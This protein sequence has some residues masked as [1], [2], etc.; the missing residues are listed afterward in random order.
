MIYL[1][2]DLFNQTYLEAYR[3]YTISWMDMLDCRNENEVYSVNWLY[4]DD[5][6]YL[7]KKYHQCY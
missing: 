4:Q 1:N 3:Q 7:P 2:A 6:M 5:V